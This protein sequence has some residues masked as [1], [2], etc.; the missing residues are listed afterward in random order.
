MVPTKPLQKT[1]LTTDRYGENM[2]LLAAFFVALALTITWQTY[3]LARQQSASPP[4][5]AVSP[6]LYLDSDAIPV[7]WDR[8]DDRQQGN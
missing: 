1:I 8:P 5:I 4:E 7:A 6:L 3:S 2:K